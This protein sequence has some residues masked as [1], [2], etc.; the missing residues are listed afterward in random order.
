MQNQLCDLQKVKTYKTSDYYE[1]GPICDYRGNMTMVSINNIITS[2]TPA[3]LTI[4]RY[5]RW[6]THTG[7]CFTPNYTRSNTYN[8][9]WSSI[10]KTLNKTI[11]IMNHFPVPSKKIKP[12]ILQSKTHCCWSLMWT[13][14]DKQISH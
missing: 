9:T 2:K 11:I 1:L 7:V 8:Y 13:G 14:T 10:R 5:H 4:T 3:L 6:L 12:L